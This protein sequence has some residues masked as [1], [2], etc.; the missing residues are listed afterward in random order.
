MFV[1]CLDIHSLLFPFL[2]SIQSYNVC[3]C[4][5]CWTQWQKILYINVEYLKYCMEWKYLQNKTKVYKIPNKLIS[6]EKIQSWIYIMLID[7]GEKLE[8]K[9]EKW[10]GKKM[11]KKFC[12]RLFC[13]E[14]ELSFHSLICLLIF[15]DWCYILCVCVC[16]CENWCFKI[17]KY[18]TYKLLKKV[19]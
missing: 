15:W 7:W 3:C 10:D 11:N 17:S 19:A 16:I 1:L 5:F 14:Y 8:N 6:K 13:H 12:R 4:L 2:Y 9:M 18:K